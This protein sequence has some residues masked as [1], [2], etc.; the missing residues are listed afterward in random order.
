[1]FVAAALSTSR[2]SSV[3]CVLISTDRAGVPPHLF[4]TWV[5]QP[6][7]FRRRLCLRI[8]S[9]HGGIRV[10]RHRGVIEEH[11]SRSDLRQHDALRKYDFAVCKHGFEQLVGLSVNNMSI[12]SSSYGQGDLPRGNTCDR[13]VAEFF[14]EN[15]DLFLR[16]K[17]WAL[18]SLSGTTVRAYIVIC[19]AA[20]RRLSRLFW[21]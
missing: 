21:V 8:L 11:S 5:Q 20:S 7:R 12:S 10:C 9:G 16:T 19:E 2:R 6:A 1:M 17:K 18:G 4:E 14:P 15:G 13:R 3:D